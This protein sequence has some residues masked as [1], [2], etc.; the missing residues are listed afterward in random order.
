MSTTVDEL[1]TWMTQPEEDEHLEFKEAK[2][3]FDFEELAKYCAALSNEGGGRIVLGVT[4]QRPRRVVGSRAFRDLGN[5]R[6][7]LLDALR[8]RIEADEIP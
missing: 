1:E 6:K 5:I 2:T 4:N 8:L 3:Q 7:R